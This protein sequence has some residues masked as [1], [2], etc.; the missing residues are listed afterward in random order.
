[1]QRH[2]MHTHNPD[3]EGSH[4]ICTESVLVVGF[5]VNQVSLALLCV[6]TLGVVGVGQIVSNKTGSSAWSLWHSVLSGACWAVLSAVHEH[7][8]L[9]ASLLLP[10]RF[11]LGQRILCLF[12]GWP[13]HSSSRQHM[14]PD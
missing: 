7:G 8:V 11:P 1:M 14:T 3:V 12:V 10:S 9:F 4:K 2:S 5:A 6:L 13:P